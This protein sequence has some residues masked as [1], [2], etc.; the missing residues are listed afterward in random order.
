MSDWVVSL[1]RRVADELV[2]FDDGRYIIMYL[3]HTRCTYC[4]VRGSI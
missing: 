4:I 3:K 2:V 1:L